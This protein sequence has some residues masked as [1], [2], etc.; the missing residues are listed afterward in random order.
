VGYTRAMNSRQGSTAL[1]VA[2]LLAFAIAVPTAA[3]SRLVGRTCVDDGVSTLT[4]R[5]VRCR[6]ADRIATAAIRKSNCPSRSDFRGCYR[7]VKVA[8]WTCHGLFP[9]E[10][11]RFTCRRGLL[12][13]HSSGGG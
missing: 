11:H 10:G 12:W 2:A 9:G 4:S 6:D 7:T 13:V 3:G 8:R 1:A 5:G